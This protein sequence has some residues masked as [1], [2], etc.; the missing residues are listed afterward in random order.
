VLQALNS[1]DG[2]ARIQGLGQ[3]LS[4]LGSE[5]FGKFIRAEYDR[6]GKVVKASGAKA[7]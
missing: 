2:S 1:P 4:P 7:D 3:T 5:D 6:W